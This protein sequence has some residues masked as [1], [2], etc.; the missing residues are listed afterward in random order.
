[1]KKLLYLTIIGMMAITSA[2]C[3]KDDKNQLVGTTWFT[4]IVISYDILGNATT[5]F[6]CIRFISNT[7]FE[8][9]RENANGIKLQNFDN[10]TYTLNYPSLRINHANTKLNGEWTFSTSTR[11]NR[12]NWNGGSFDDVYNKR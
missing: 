11:F 2:G 8:F 5:G 4:R 6:H 7:E 1:M 10:G 12:H 3:K 9:W